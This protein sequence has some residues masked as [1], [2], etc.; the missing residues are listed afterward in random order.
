MF[1]HM[2]CTDEKALDERIAWYDGQLR[3]IL[4]TAREMDPQ[5][6]MTVLSDHGMTPVSNYYDLMKEVTATGYVLKKDY[7]A[8]YD[9]TMARFW[10]FNDAARRDITAVLNKAPSGRIVS[11]EELRALGVFFDDRRFGEVIFLLRP[12]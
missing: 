2:H 7:L 9:S 8:V 10:F 6:T 3:N 12:G 1:L 11:D 5:A 4:A